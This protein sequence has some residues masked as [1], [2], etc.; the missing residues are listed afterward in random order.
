MQLLGADVSMRQLTCE[1]VGLLVL[2][3][4]VTRWPRRRRAAVT[5]ET[6]VP[7][8]GCPWA[9]M[10]VAGCSRAFQHYT[11]VST[12]QP[13]NQGSSVVKLRRRRRHG[14]AVAGS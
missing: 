11:R 10:M 4:P 9:A 5:P 3:Q 13:A 2:A 6:S 1:R 12:S 8:A 14:K 7:P